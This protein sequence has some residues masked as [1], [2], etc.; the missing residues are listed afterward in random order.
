MDS[1]DVL[2]LPNRTGMGHLLRSG[3]I[4][5]QLTSEGIKVALA[6]SGAYSDLIDENILIDGTRSDYDDTFLTLDAQR[7][8]SYLM[9]YE[10][11]E[12]IVDDEIALLE[13]IKPKLVVGDTR[14]CLRI[15]SGVCNTKYISL[16]NANMTPYYDTVPNQFAQFCQDAVEP[17]NQLAR[18]RGLRFRI[19]SFN[20]VCIGETNLICD[21]EDFLP[22]YDFPAE[23]YVYTGPIL[24]SVGAPDTSEAINE[25]RKQSRTLVYLTLGG[26]GTARLMELIHSIPTETGTHFVISSARRIQAKNAENIHFFEFVPMDTLSYFDLCVNQGG[27]GTIYQCIARGLPMVCFPSNPDQYYNS[28]RVDELGIGQMIDLDDVTPGEILGIIHNLIQSSG[29]KK[30]MEPLSVKVKESNSVRRTCDIIKT[31]LRG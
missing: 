26:T 23:R 17:F 29:I 13:R 5:K 21:L 18:K 14:F 9:N 4:A 7:A 8:L 12:T 27:N 31:N 25:I 6:Y 1:V 19:S 10:R 28:C 3:C 2:F 16:L 24:T 20:D 11:L 30:N 22:L 15:S